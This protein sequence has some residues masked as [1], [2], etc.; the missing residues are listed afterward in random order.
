[1]EIGN[2]PIEARV[3]VEVEMKANDETVEVVTG[4]KVKVRVNDQP[5]EGVPLPLWGIKEGP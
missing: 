1:M 5:T 3:G 4:R 2:Q